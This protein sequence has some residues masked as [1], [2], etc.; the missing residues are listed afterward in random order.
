MF[1]HHWIKYYIS[2]E[3]FDICISWHKIIMFNPISAPLVSSMIVLGLNITTL[4]DFSWMQCYKSNHICLTLVHS[5][6]NKY[7]R[8]SGSSVHKA[9][10]C[11]SVIFEKQRYL[12]IPRILCAILYWN[13]NNEVSFVMNFRFLKISLQ[14]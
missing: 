7:N 9:H 11:E 4:S 10:V 13:Q 2:F 12:F 14:L 5:K 1:E 8:V 6:K 3:K